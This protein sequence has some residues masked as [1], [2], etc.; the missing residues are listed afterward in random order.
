MS[1]TET[2]HMEADI[3]RLSSELETLN[4]R[5]TSRLQASTPRQQRRKL[6][7]EIDEDA[8]G[9]VFEHRNVSPKSS[10]RSYELYEDT[11]RMPEPSGY[12]GVSPEK[13]RMPEPSGYAGVLPEK[14]HMPEPSGYS[15]Y[16]QDRR[17]ITDPSRYHSELQERR[18]MPDPSDYRSHFPERRPV[19]EP[20]G[21]D[22][23]NSVELSNLAELL[24][25]QQDSLPRMEPENQS[26]P[27]KVYALLDPQSDSCFIKDDVLDKLGA[28]GPTL[29]LRLSTMLAEDSIQCKKLA[30]L[31]IKNM[32]STVDLAM[33]CTY[34]R[35]CIPAS[36]SLIPKKETV[37]KWS[38]LREVAKKLYSYEEDLEIGLLIGTNCAQVLKPREV[39]P[40]ESNEPNGIWTDLGWGVIR[41]VTQGL[42]EEEESMCKMVSSGQS[43]RKCHFALRTSA[44]EITTQRVTEMFEMEFHEQQSDKTLSMEYRK[45]M[46]K[47]KNGIY[48]LEDGHFVLPLPL[49]NDDIRLP[50]NRQMAVNRLNHLKHKMVKNPQFRKD[51]T[52]F[53]QDMLD[54][55]HAEPIPVTSKGTTGQVWYVPHHGV[56]NP[57]KPGKICV[58]YDCSAEF[59]GEALNRQ[60]L[61]GPDLTNNLC[62]VLTQFRKEPIAFTCDI[63]K[64][65]YEVIVEEG[66]R[67]LLRFLWWEDGKLDTEPKD[68]RMTR[69]IFGAT[70]SPGCANYAMKETSNRYEG[71]FGKPTADFI[72][73]NFYVDDEAQSVVTTQEA[74]ELIVKS[75]ELCKK[76]GF[77]LHKYICNDKDVVSKIPEEFR[78]ATIQSFDSHSESLPV[79]RILGI[80]W[81][82][83]SDTLQFAITLK[84]KPLARHGILS[85]VSSVF[86]PLGLVAPVILEGKRIVQELC[87]DNKG[88]DDPIPDSIKTRWKAWRS[89]LTN[90]TQ[91]KIP[92]CYRPP[93]KTQHQKPRL[94]ELHHFSDASLLGGYGQCSY[95]RRVEENGRTSTALVM[96][97]F[98][99]RPSKPTTVPRLELTAAVSS[100]KISNFLRA[101]LDYTQDVIEHFWTDSKVVLGYISNEAKRFHIFVA[102]RVQQIRNSTKPEQ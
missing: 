87:R 53:M 65:F 64:M 99:V 22:V 55:G 69:H 8:Q 89:Q 26:V 78:A 95:V 32:E 50:E 68:Y 21:H 81:C 56:Y 4:T 17:H 6:I 33:P 74:T 91:F 62:G 76:G 75:R 67:D 79:E 52:A 13:H 31:R 39:V 10:P 98:R 73:R 9:C 82:V 102:N 51:Y 34:S 5:L 41:I 44:K 1:D 90:L 77:H 29:T 11:H 60:L 61:Q 28:D 59:K 85:T 36:H 92:R 25:N 86:D 57:Q 72:R 101:D 88:W 83:E 15:S 47:A 38:H 96:A 30:G 12:P 80:R 43:E 97:K 27:V 63:R 19:P 23:A 18:Y 37:I 66:H 84:E 48:Q 35:Q 45:F 54:Q 3:R 70:S 16:L 24:A 7:Q 2:K 100:V 46:E 58:V 14:H 42:E 93:D 40:G 49:K 20:S 71:H 94:L